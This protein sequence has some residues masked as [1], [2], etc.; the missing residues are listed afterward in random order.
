MGDFFRNFGDYLVFVLIALGGFAGMAWGLRRKQPRAR[1]SRAFWLALVALLVAGHFYVEEAGRRPQQRLITLLEGIAPTYA[2]ELS[3]MGHAELTVESAAGDPRYLTMI[4]ALKR[5]VAANPLISDIYTFRK[6][7]DGQVILLV[8]AET[9]YDGD[10]AFTGSTEARTEPGELYPQAGPELMAAFDGKENF[11]SR[12]VTDRWGTWVSVHVPMRD[13]SGRVEAVLGVDYRADLWGAESAERRNLAMGYLGVVLLILLG[14]AAAISVYRAELAARVEAEG[15]LRAGLAALE[16]EN[17]ERRAAERARHEA[18]AR[19]ALHVEQ[20]PLAYVE[21]GANL[22]VTRWNRAA[23]RIFGYSAGEACGSAFTDLIVPESARR[24]VAEVCERL[25]ARLVPVRHTNENITKEGRVIICEWHNTPLVNARGELLAVAS[26]AQDI[27]ERVRLEQHMRQGQKMESMGQLAGGVAHEFNNLLTP[28]LMQMGQMQAAYAD[29]RRLQEMLRPVEE[30]IMQAAQL[31]QRILAVGRRQPDT[32]APGDLNRMIEAGMELLRHTLDRRIESKIELQP[33]LPRALLSKGAIA[34]VVMNLALNARDTLLEKLSAGAPADW[35]PRLRV[36]TGLVERPPEGAPERLRLAG[37]CLTLTVT[38]N[39]EGM[40]PD[41]QKRIFE[42]FFTT[43][44]AGKGTGLGLAVVWGVVESLC[45]HLQLESTPGVGSVFTVYIP[46]VR[47]GAMEAVSTRQG[48]T[49]AGRIESSMRGAPMRV[50]LV[51]DNQLVRET[52]GDALRQAG[53][54]V[55]CAVDGEAGWRA[56][57]AAAATPYDLLLADLNLP[58]LSGR[59]LLNRVRGLGRSRS[60]VVLSG[61][62]DLRLTPELVDLGVDAVLH[63]P[64]GM[65]ELLA[66][67]GDVSRR[68]A[69]RGATA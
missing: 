4:A 3:R 45:G 65:S 64:I 58:R 35:T 2:E 56:L 36:S 33:G 48:R 32:H 5:W 43:K 68:M 31:N 67:L 50:L 66:A 55:V 41:V 46:V 25:S 47:E 38:D 11:M 22:R 1:L 14:S 8:D 54:E 53:H 49:V 26:H 60:V 51:E 28:M 10:G 19:L 69:G 7:A 29:D 42:P 18:D 40:G 24:E 9:D 44:P 6:R 59:E 20:T 16:H 37:A 30:A 27:T 63:K 13:A 23:E 17:T 21:W 62:S 52:L 61:M 39:G 12:P 57:E 34:Q 15:R